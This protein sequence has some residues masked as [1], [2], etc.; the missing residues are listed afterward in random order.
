[1]APPA[2]HGRTERRGIDLG[3]DL[4]DVWDPTDEASAG[5]VPVP[6]SVVGDVV[7]FLTNLF[8]DVFEGGTASS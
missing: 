8:E 7:S 4:L 6:V 1:M 3:L 5:G 2:R